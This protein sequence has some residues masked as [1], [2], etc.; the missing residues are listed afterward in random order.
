VSKALVL[1]A[2]DGAAVLSHMGELG[3]E[4]EL[5]ELR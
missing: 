5:V 3:K 2:G 4:Q 1:G